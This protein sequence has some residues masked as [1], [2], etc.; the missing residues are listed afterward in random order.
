MRTGLNFEQAVGFP[1]AF[2]AGVDEVGRGCLAGPVVAGA[3]LLPRADFLRTP[4]DWFS[5]IT[6]SKMLT[7]EDRVRLAPLI[8]E[9]LESAGGAWGLGQASVTEIDTINIYHASHLAMVRAIDAMAADLRAREA[10]GLSEQSLAVLIDGNAIPLALR[11]DKAPSYVREVRAIVKGDLQCF[12]IACASILAK[13]WR[14]AHMAEL[15]VQ[16]PGYGLAAH[17]GYS[18]PQHKQALQALGARE[19]HRR[20]FAPVRDVLRPGS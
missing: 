12:S 10:R 13:V 19:I 5:E 2:V 20:S 7:H 16:Y 6:D 18:T 3:V 15:D 4:R 1:N 14:D 8:R 9:W 17:K 11:P